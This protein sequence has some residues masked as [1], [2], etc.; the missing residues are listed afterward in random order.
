MS[1]LTSSWRVCNR[2]PL[3]GWPLKD[4]LSIWFHETRQPLLL[5]GREG[6]S[7]CEVLRF[8]VAPWALT[9]A[10]PSPR[11]PLSYLTA[12]LLQSAALRKLFSLASHAPHITGSQ[13]MELAL[14]KYLMSTPLQGPLNGGSRQ[15]WGRR[16]ARMGGAL[17]QLCGRSLQPGY[18]VNTWN[19][20]L[21]CNRVV[22]MG[23]EELKGHACYC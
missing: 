15:K 19:T 21:A 13:N 22:G 9:P 5:G 2:D 18:E 20:Q 10:L 11:L 7:R 3:P 4:V 6:D 16:T 23:C 12:V 1:R 14:K 17:G 8:C